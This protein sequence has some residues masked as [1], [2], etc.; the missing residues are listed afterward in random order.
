[1]LASPLASPRDVNKMLRKPFISLRESCGSPRNTSSNRCAQSEIGEI[2]RSGGRVPLT[3]IICV[4]TSCPSLRTLRPSRPNH[5]PPRK[6]RSARASS[7]AG[8]GATPLFET[9]QIC[10]NFL[11]L[12]SLSGV[13]T[14][15]HCPL[16]PPS[17]RPLIKHAK[18]LKAFL[19]ARPR[20]PPVGYFKK[21]SF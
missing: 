12:L 1:M 21:K 7:E 6:S 17:S 15:S 11:P 8:G 14:K 16:P 5:A 2:G 9:V 10:V 19:S 3:S 4:A 13:M 20:S 18:I